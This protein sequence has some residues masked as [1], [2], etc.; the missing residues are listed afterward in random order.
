MRG[1]ITISTIETPQLRLALPPYAR[2]SPQS[3][4]TENFKTFWR[5]TKERYCGYSLGIC[6]QPK[7]LP[8]PR[9]ALRRD[10]IHAPAAR[11]S[12]PAV[13]ARRPIYPDCQFQR[14]NLPAP[15]SASQKY[16]DN[17]LPL[18]EA[19]YLFVPE[20]GIQPLTPAVYPLT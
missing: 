11:P 12:T 20:R 17:R 1:L 6:S 19:Y 8:I 2:P 16:L 13:V 9:Y 10:A 18:H 15:L 4:V 7:S 3:K 5:L 14:L